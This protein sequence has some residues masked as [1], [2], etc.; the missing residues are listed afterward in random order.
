LQK[1]AQLPAATQVYCAHEYTLSNLRFAQAVEPDNNDLQQRSASDQ[2]KR[3][4]D[5][6]TVPSVLSV[7]LATNPFLRCEENSVRRAAES[8]AGRS[9][10][11]D[12]EVFAIL[13]SWKDDF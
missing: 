7:E 12:A 6:A 1:L 13:R 2:Q 8:F 4:R 3:K 11:S 10:N 5:Q 9:T